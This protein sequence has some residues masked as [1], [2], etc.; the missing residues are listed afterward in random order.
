[1]IWK[2]TQGLF[3]I[4]PLFGWP[5]WPLVKTLF[6]FFPLIYFIEVDP[7][8]FLFWKQKKLWSFRFLNKDVSSYPNLPH[9]ITIKLRH[10]QCDSVQLKVNLEQIES[11][12]LLL[13]KC[14]E[15]KNFLNAKR[16]FKNVDPDKNMRMGSFFSP[17][18][19][20]FHLQKKSL[21]LIL[22]SMY[23]ITWKYI[24]MEY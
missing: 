6:C 14:N 13:H 22:I 4:I 3:V 21:N 10:E 11:W 2:S 16:V 23:K 1:M 7:V 8:I 24:L 5:H 15:R 9:H 20:N 19:Q 18:E 12:I 17:W